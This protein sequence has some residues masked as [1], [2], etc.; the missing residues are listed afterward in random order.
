MTDIAQRIPGVVFA[1]MVGAPDEDG[2]RLA[3]WSNVLLRAFRGDPADAPAIRAARAELVEYVEVL[4][5]SRRSRPGEDIVSCLVA[6]V[7]SGLITDDDLHALATEMLAASTDNTAHS[8]GI[9]LWLLLEH[10]EQWTAIAS[11]HTL[12]PNAI[13]ECLR[14][15]P[16]TRI[17]PTIALEGATICGIELPEGAL[18]NLDL[19]AA[20][21]DPAVWE[22]PDVLDILRRLERRQLNFGVGRHYCL[23]AA[24]ARMELVTILHALVDSWSEATLDGQ[25]LLRLTLD[26]SVD[27]LPIAFTPVC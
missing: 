22:Q 1:W 9:I 4:V 8:A 6:A 15:E 3:N 13:E 17:M 11:N 23:G 7:D 26:G 21:R 20:H 12:I 24:L 10:S 27:K 5:A 18:V 14:F 25:P 2:E 16:R 19:A